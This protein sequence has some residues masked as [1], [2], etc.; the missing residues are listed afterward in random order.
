M[1]GRGHP[2]G[3]QPRGIGRAHAP[4]VANGQIVQGRGAHLR[5]AQIANAVQRRRALGQVVSHLGQGLGGTKPDTC[6]N[7]GPLADRR[8]QGAGVADR[9]GETAEIEEALV[10]AVDDDLGREPLIDGVHAP[11]HVAVE[12]VV[13]R[14]GGDPLPGAKLADLEI[15][16][17]HLQADRLGLGAARDD[18]AVIGRQHH[19]RSSFQ[20]RIEDPLTRN[21]EAIAVA[22]RDHRPHRVG[23]CARRDQAT[24]PQMLISL[25]GSG[26]KG[27]DRGLS[28]LRVGRPAT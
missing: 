23:R 15:G 20:A 10:N 1:A 27:G 9:I 14:Q 26:A 17:A 2:H 21:V 19:G 28:W 18:V 25:C 16:I 8:A 13:R 3:R 7:P 12:N 6:R 4:D 11:A 24:T 5:V 22:Q